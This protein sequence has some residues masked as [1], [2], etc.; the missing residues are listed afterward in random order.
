M[1]EIYF[2]LQPWLDGSRKFG[3][4]LRRGGS[5][6]HIFK[7]LRCFDFEGHG[8]RS[9]TRL[10]SRPAMVIPHTHTVARNIKVNVSW[11]KS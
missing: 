5:Q 10:N 7:L 11:F 8:H 3:L 9:E 4:C 6:E 1:K 2:R